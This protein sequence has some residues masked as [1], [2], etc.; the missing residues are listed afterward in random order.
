MGEGLCLKLVLDRRK[1]NGKLDPRLALVDVYCEAG[2][3]AHESRSKDTGR[4]Q[5][6]RAPGRSKQTV[7]NC[8]PPENTAESRNAQ[9]SAS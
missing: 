2:C 7:V 9:C 1:F 8:D 5:K 3:I 6:S 4:E